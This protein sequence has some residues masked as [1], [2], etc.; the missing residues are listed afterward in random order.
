MNQNIVWT[1]ARIVRPRQLAC[2]A[3]DLK[4]AWPSAWYGRTGKLAAEIEC[5]DSYSDEIMRTGEHGWLTL[6]VLD[7]SRRPLDSIK[8]APKF[9]TFGEAKLALQS[10]LEKWGTF[11]PQEFQV[12]V[13]NYRASGSVGRMYG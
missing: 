9:E 3:L 6:S 5:A 11:V 2:Q 7:H 8:I 12:R 1:E 10:V 13:P 4:Q